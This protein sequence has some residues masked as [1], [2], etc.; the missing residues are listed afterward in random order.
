MKYPQCVQTVT[1]AGRIPEQL[2]QLLVDSVFA[3]RER[4]FLLIQ[5]ESKQKESEAK[6]YLDRHF[7]SGQ[8]ESL[9]NIMLKSCSI[10]YRF[11]ITLKR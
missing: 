1:L 11:H 8:G 10:D 4:G 3:P 9:S 5:I 2:P 6:A 7:A